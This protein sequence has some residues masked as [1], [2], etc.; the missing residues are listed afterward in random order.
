MHGLHDITCEP[1]WASEELENESEMTLELFGFVK[2][3]VVTSHSP[4]L[5]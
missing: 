4:T 2:Q 3:S 5:D 1:M